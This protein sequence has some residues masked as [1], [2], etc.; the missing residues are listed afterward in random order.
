MAHLV[1]RNWRLEWHRLPILSHS[2]D[3]EL[4]RMCLVY[5]MKLPIPFY[6]IQKH[7]REKK[8]LGANA[9]EFSLYSSKHATTPNVSSMNSICLETM[10]QPQSWLGMC[11]AYPYPYTQPNCRTQH[12]NLCYKFK[13]LTQYIKY[14]CI[15]WK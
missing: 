13:N 14:I 2:T 7:E 6:W 12:P 5:R 1:Y 10:I 11:Y 4:F 8:D 15:S 9:F 3:I